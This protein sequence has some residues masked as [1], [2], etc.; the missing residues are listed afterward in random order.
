[1][2]IQYTRI[3]STVKVQH[4]RATPSTWW[5]DAGPIKTKK[6]AGLRVEKL[7]RG[8][9]GNKLRHTTAM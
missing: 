4:V 2:P 9:L 1:M 5:G 8:R 3:E 6:Q 7:G